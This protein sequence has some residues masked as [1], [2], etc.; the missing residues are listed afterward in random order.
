M[1]PSGIE[2]S[3]NKSDGFYERESIRVLLVRKSQFS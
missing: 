3:N 1:K 2:T